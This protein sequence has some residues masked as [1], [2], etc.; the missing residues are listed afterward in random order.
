MQKIF[1]ILYYVVARKLP[2]SYFPLGNFFNSFRVLTLNKLINV[3]NNT[4][5]QS[6]FRFGLNKP[7]TIG[8]NCDINENVYV[9]SAV[10]GNNVLIAQN[11]V[12]L[13]ITHNFRDKHMI[14]RHQGNTEAKTVI[15]E[16]DVWI[17]RNVI[18]LPG[19]VLGKGSVIGAGAVVTKNVSPYTIVGGVPAK[20]IG[21]R[22]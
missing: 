3:G 17:G 4:V 21:E 14:I 20:V 12:I 6:G 19:I 8:D 10:I 5:I 9:Q 18:V 15:V 16:D 11:V 1:L 13:A 7:L 2:S 22:N